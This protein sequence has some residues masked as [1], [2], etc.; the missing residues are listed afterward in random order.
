MSRQNDGFKSY[1]QQAVKNRS[2]RYA[3][4]LFLFILLYKL[5]ELVFAYLDTTRLFSTLFEAFYYRLSAVITLASVKVYSLFYKEIYST[6]DFLIV[7]NDVRTIQMQ[8]GCTGLMQLFQIFFILMFF[9]LTLKKKLFYF[10]VSFFV[11][12]FAALLHYLILIEI[13]H[14]HREHFSVFHDTITRVIFYTFFFLNFI[15]WIKTAKQ[16]RRISCSD[17]D[18][19]QP[20]FK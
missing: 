17:T 8:H 15:L 2:I 7:I 20:K 12:V 13:A 9:P 19:D 14:S 3:W 11:I 18:A 4:Q 10:P 16:N 6:S 5:G 1:F